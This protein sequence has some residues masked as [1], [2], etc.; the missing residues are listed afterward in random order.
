MIVG[1][2]PASH[3]LEYP[4]WVRSP[5]SAGPKNLVLGHTNENRVWLFFGVVLF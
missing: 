5:S 2:I 1:Q 4:K 3:L